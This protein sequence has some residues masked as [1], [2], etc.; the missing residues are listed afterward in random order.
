MDYPGTQYKIE[1]DITELD[2]LLL[3]NVEDA[4]LH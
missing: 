4:V 2:T 3:S 1:S